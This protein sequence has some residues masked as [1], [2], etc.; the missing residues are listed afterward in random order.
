[1]FTT[2]IDKDLCDD[3]GATRSSDLAKVARMYFLDGPSQA[4]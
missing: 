1:M 2:V 3:A 4:D